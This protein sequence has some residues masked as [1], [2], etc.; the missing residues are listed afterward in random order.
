MADC[1][2]EEI[3]INI[4]HRLPVKALL[5]C[6]AVCKSWYS[7]ITSPEFISSHLKFTASRQ[8]IAP[9]LLLRRCI[10]GS[11]R[12]DLYS[13]NE[14]LSRFASFDFPFRSINSFFTVV[15]S[16]NGLLCLSDDRNFHM[17]TIVLWNPCIKKSV[18]LPKP[19]MIY[20][21]YGSFIQCLGFGFDHF[22][23]DY[24]VVR[25][26]YVDLATQPQIEVYKLS[27]GVWQ[28]VSDLALEYFVCNRSHQV[29]VNGAAHWIAGC[30]EF[31]DLIVLFDMSRE[32][33]RTMMLPVRLESNDPLRNHDLAVYGDSLAL[34]L[35]NV[36][37][38]DPRFCVWVMKEYGVEES[39]T[40]NLCFDL[41][42]IGI[43]FIRP[44]WI[45]KKGEVVV[46]WQG[47]HLVSYD[48]GGGEVKDLGIR[49]SRSDT[50]QHSLHVDRYLSSLVLLERGPYFSDSA[51]GNSLPA[52][53]G[54]WWELWK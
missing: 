9:L 29:Y 51:T 53:R 24:K 31:Y 47:G 44:L 54:E 2:F 40:K 39:W 50:Y 28:D 34:I 32:I 8:K 33:F 3:I 36:S 46:V 4:L 22:G 23:N 6:T 12:Y 27:S 20:S 52:L 37:G 41:G 18:L 42:S 10:K 14:S 49:G 17:N 15:G 43:G 38:A 21:S 30:M 1:L 35:W 13:D 5:R 7:L 11:E 45:R 19:N 48:H 16:C 26:T 25:I